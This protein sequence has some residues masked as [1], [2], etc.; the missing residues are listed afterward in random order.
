MCIIDT[1]CVEL[2]EYQLNGVTRI[3]YG[4]GKKRG[5]NY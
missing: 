4:K 3:L 2:V 1:D 5:L